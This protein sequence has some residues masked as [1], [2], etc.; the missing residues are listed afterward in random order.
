MGPP[1]KV[2]LDGN[3]DQKTLAAFKFTKTISHRSGGVEVSIPELERDLP[4]L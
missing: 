3:A 2:K 4:A 1:K